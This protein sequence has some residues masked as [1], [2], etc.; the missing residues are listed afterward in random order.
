MEGGAWQRPGAGAP[1]EPAVPE[2]RRDAFVACSSTRPRPSRPPRC[3][4][5]SPRAGPP[6]WTR[7]G[8]PHGRRRP[9]SAPTRPAP[10]ASPTR[11]C[12]IRC[13]ARS[14]WRPTRRVAARGCSSGRPS[15]ARS[16]RARTPWWSS[17]TARSG[18]AGSSSP[19][20]S[21]AACSASCGGTCASSRDSSWS[22]SRCPPAM[23]RETGKRDAVLA[24][25]GEAPH[26]AALA[27]RRPRAVCRRPRAAGPEPPARQGAG[28][29][30][31][32]ADVR[33]VAA[34]SG[35]FRPAGALGLVDAPSSPRRT[36]CRGSGRI[37]TTRFTSLRWRSAGTA[38]RW[39]GWRP[40]PLCGISRVK[41]GAKTSC[42]DSFDTCNLSGDQPV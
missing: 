6:D 25:I 24:E 26:L 34:V 1:T 3:A 39:P 15:S 29:A 7:P 20:A 4:A 27:A 41:P 9:R 8:S 16:S 30:H 23:R 13:A 36:V 2:V 11:R 35:D 37:A 19:P 32:P 28:P 22:P 42:W 10:C 38:T 12:S 33:V 21:R 14:P 5:S 40:G 31:R 18:P 17:S